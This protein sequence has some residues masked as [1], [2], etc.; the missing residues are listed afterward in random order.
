MVLRRLIETT[1]IIG[2]VSFDENFTSPVTALTRH[3]ACDNTPNVRTNSP[4][5]SLQPTV[6]HLLWLTFV[7]ICAFF[8]GR[9]LAAYWGKAGWAVGGLVGIACGFL[10][11][12]SLWLLAGFY[13]R[14]RPLRP[15]CRRGRCHSEDYKMKVVVK[16]SSWE[17]ENQCKCGDTY[18]KRG[19]RFMLLQPDGSTKAYM[20]RKPC[21]DWEADR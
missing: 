9:N 18:V 5:Q 1:R 19:N 3:I 7:V 16:E 20:L 14:F 11:L 2:Q 8:V 21:H 6:F 10:L 17:S 12:Y 15:T 13:H 4:P